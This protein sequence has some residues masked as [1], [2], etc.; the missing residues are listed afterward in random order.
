M[1]DIILMLFRETRKKPLFYDHISNSPI[2]VDIEPGVDASKCIAY[3]PGLE[4]GIKDTLPT[5]FT[6]QAKDS[7]GEDFKEGGDKFDVVIQGPHGEY[8]PD[9]TDN[10]DGTYNVEY[11]PDEPGLHTVK[12]NL[13]GV[14]IKDS[15]FKVR[16]DPGADHSHS[17]I[18]RFTFIVRTRDKRG[19][20]RTTGGDNVTVTIAD[21]HGHNL[22]N[23]EKKDIGDGTYLVIYSLP[24]DYVP[25]EYTIHTQI[26]GRDIKGSPWKQLFK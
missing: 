25:G 13:E 18:E 6:I 19:A 23:V 16:V 20:N 11:Q 22:E 9:V 8:K 24:E 15:P 7:N 4:D 1:G 21:P 26:N 14:P 3:G 12:V 10:G 17:F 2:D 5:Y